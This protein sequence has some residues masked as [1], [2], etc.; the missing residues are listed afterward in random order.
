[1]GNNGQIY[2]SNCHIILKK[3]FDKMLAVAD[4]AN[5]DDFMVE[6]CTYAVLKQK[7]IA[8]CF[9]FFNFNL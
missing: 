7:I 6:V 9:N 3:E 2:N 4:L 8:M 5:G 1:M